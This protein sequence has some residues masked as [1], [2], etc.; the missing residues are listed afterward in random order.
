MRRETRR[1]AASRY[2]L[3][4]A[5][6][7]LAVGMACLPLL[8]AAVP[9]AAYDGIPGKPTPGPPEDPDTVTLNA[10]GD[11]MLSRKV[12]KLIEQ[13]G[14]GYPMA[15]LGGELAKADLT[16]CNLESPIS[17]L[18]RPLPGKQITFRAPPAA[19]ECLRQAGVD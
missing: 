9:D 4:A 13:N 17:R 14:L 19:V 1:P 15:A 8:P 18:G 7:L 3:L 6:A 5:L 10:V 2:W 11:V 12:A 16:F